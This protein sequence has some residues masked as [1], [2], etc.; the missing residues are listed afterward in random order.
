MQ[1]EAFGQAI[2]GFSSR[3]LV[4]QRS[5]A[6]LANK[7]V[8][9]SPPEVDENIRRRVAVSLISYESVNGEASLTVQ[10]RNLRQFFHGRNPQSQRDAQTIA[11]EGFHV[12]RR[13]RQGAGVYYGS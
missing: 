2:P 5:V 4:E 11:S 10:S 1:L 13:R 12:G 6:A 8:L 3:P 9:K 7:V